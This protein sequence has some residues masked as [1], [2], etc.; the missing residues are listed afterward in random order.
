[1]VKYFY[2]VLNRLKISKYFN[3]IIHKKINGD[4]LKIPIIYNIGMEHFQISEIW[5]IP[6]LKSILKI[7][8]GVFFDIGVNTGQTLLKLRSVSKEI[9]YYG[10]EPN[11]KCVFY[12]EELIR[13]NSF[14]NCVIIPVGI[15]TNNELLRLNFFSESETDSS[16]SLVSDFRPNEKTYNSKLVPVFNYNS[17]NLPSVEIAVLKIDVEGA[18]LFVIEA[19]I[20]KIKV[21]QPLI[22]MEILPTY[23]SENK[24]R[25]NKQKTLETLLK[26]CGYIFYRIMK[27]TNPISLNCITEIEIH[28]DMELVEYLILPNSFHDQIVKEF[29]IY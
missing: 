4:N 18:E 24:E 17:I 20:E 8:D 23:H 11:P 10:F 14:K 22:L 2:K 6:I 16:A 19:L 27:E 13:V 12:A 1:M 7:K 15:M 28:S 3:F 29:S 21:D 25:I 5:M 9:P 26:N